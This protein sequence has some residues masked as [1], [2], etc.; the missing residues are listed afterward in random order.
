R[1]FDATRAELTESGVEFE[2]Y[3]DESGVTTNEDGVF[4]GPGFKA[5]WFKDP[6]GN[7]FSINEAS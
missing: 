1:D 3:D 5:A 6:D 2:H 7:I 4:V